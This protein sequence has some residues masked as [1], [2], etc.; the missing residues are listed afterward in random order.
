[1]TGP[2]R[3]GREDQACLTELA[4][5]GLGSDYEGLLWEMLGSVVNLRELRSMEVDVGLISAIG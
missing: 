1:M 4:A 5:A 2:G 3:P